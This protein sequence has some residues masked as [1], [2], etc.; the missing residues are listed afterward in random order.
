[1]LG[2]GVD[3]D[4][5]IGEDEDLIGLVGEP[6]DDHEEVAGDGFDPRG[7]S[8]GEGSGLDNG[9]G[10]GG[11]AGDHGVGVVGGDHHAA[12]KEGLGHHAA[13]DA[14]SDVVPPFHVLRDVVVEAEAFLGVSGFNSVERD[15]GIV[16][17]LFDL[18]GSSEDDVL[19]DVAFADLGSGQGDAGVTSLRQNH[20]KLAADDAGGEGVNDVG[21]GTAGIQLD[22]RCSPIGDVWISRDGSSVAIG[23]RRAKR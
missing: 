18:L 10:G 4:G 12:M 22:H 7:E 8:D 9:G 5:T 17:G 20:T 19:G 2:V 1:M 3:V 13:G 11:G 23:G 16:G 6:G 14:F 15:A 21:P